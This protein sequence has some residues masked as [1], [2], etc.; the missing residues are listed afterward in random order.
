MLP[1]N[2]SLAP[3]DQRLTIE[4]SAPVEDGGSDLLGFRV[5]AR[6]SNPQ[7]MWDPAHTF[8]SDDVELR[9]HTVFLLDNGTNYD[10]CVL[11]FNAN[12][13]G[14]CE[15]LSAT[16]VSTPG[17]P[18]SPF[19]DPGDR[20]IAMEWTAPFEDGGSSR[21]SYLLQYRERD[22]NTGWITAAGGAGV[23]SDA[24]TFTVTR[25]RNGVEYDVSVQA[26]NA[27]GYGER[28]VW[29]GEGNFQSPSTVPG[30]PGSLRLARGDGVI[31]LEWS[32][33]DDGGRQIIEYEVLHT[34]DASQD[35]ENWPRESIPFDPSDDPSQPVSDEISG[36]MNGVKHSVCVRTRNSNGAGECAMAT[37]TPAGLPSAPRELTAQ[38]QDGSALLSW[39][40]PDQLGGVPILSYEVNVRTVGDTGAGRTLS[41]NAPADPLLS[42]PATISSL[43][44]NNTFALR[45]TAVNEVGAGDPAE[46]AV[47]PRPRPAVVRDLVATPATS[48]LDVAWVR[49]TNGGEAAVTGYELQFRRKAASEP[50][51]HYTGMLGAAAASATIEQLVP[52]EVHQV[53]VRAVHS[54]LLIGPW[55]TVE[56]TPVAPP[57]LSVGRSSAVEDNSDGVISFTV[58]L[59]TASPAQ[60]VVFDFETVQCTSSIAVCVGLEP[61]TQGTAENPGTDYLGRSFTFDTNADTPVIEEAVIG[62]GET[63]TVVSVQIFDDS[64]EEGD[65]VFLLRL[66]NPRGAEFPEGATS[67]S[68]VGT[69]IDNDTPR[70]TEP[71]PPVRPP[72]VLPPPVDDPPDMGD[73]DDADDPPDT[74]DDDDADDP[75]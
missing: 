18:G 58:T 62:S 3:L 19:G 25:L 9:T 64:E 73:D 14:A 49:P 60:R 23:A 4:W 22:R 2:V 51:T 53:R 68:V 69:I 36:L 37:A 21:D 7:G 30:V 5:F 15:Q 42:V 10:L 65:E 13:D 8:R 52:D 63:E 66:S 6:E 57:G 70:P 20:Q 11:A 41:I 46:V 33:P 38:E 71:P 59:N 1:V 48:A 39:L 72:P 12:G 47:T 17:A 29:E 35:L 26:H 44:N 74:G 24:T 34:P 28:A 54:D 55:L 43:A 32:A 56:A 16:P 45:V 67:L 50:W 75:P 40:P 31:S 61:G 27:Q